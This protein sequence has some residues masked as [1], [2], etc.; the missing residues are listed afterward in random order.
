MRKSLRDFKTLDALN[1]EARRRPV[2][3]RTIEI[4]EYQPTNRRPETHLAL[5][6]TVTLLAA[7]H[8]SKFLAEIREAV[9]KKDGSGEEL[10]RR[11][12]R[13]YKGR[14]TTTLPKAVKSACAEPVLAD[15]LH[16]D[17]LL[18]ESLFVPRDLEVAFIALPYNGG[19]FADGGLL[20]VE[21]PL[22]EDVESL[23]VVALAH[24]PN[25]TNAERVALA[26]VPPEQSAL[27]IGNPLGP[28]ACGVG[29]LVA[30]VVVEAV[31]VA[32][33]FAITG[34]VDIEHMAHLS[35]A[36]LQELRPAASARE[37][38]QM[39]RAYLGKRSILAKS[40]G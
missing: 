7:R 16:G 27:N 20:L 32:V 38:V 10:A 19:R 1:T 40:G 2:R 29:L 35:A 3:R 37:L 23:E 22:S 13:Q 31:V 39:R 24:A 15:V 36:E 21:H 17:L 8:G 14:K 9:A 33:T 18:V 11:M 28:I 4:V 34:K 25:L 26:N 6:G 12:Y 5:E 30:A